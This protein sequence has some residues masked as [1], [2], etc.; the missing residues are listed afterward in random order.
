MV[1]TSASLQPRCNKKALPSARSRVFMKCLLQRHVLNAL[2]RLI[3]A[4]DEC[5]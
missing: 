1:T 5:D 3:V 4:V 2:R